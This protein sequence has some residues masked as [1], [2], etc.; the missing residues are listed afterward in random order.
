MRLA[1]DHTNEQMQQKL[2][3]Y[4][5]TCFHALELFQSP[6][7]FRGLLPLGKDSVLLGYICAAPL[8][9][10]ALYAVVAGAVSDSL[11]ATGRISR[12]NMQKVCLNM[13]V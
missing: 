10:Y 4:V 13:L 8:L 3:H 5:A 2:Q 9:S 11:I 6:A 12:L 7:F 1:R